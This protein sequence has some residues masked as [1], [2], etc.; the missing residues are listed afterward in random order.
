[1]KKYQGHGGHD[2]DI[3]KLSAAALVKKL[4]VDVTD[5]KKI[6]DK[7]PDIK[8]QL[9]DL[10]TTL[11]MLQNVKPIFHCGAKT[12]ALGPHFGLDPQCE[13]C[14]G[15]ANMLVSKNAKMCVTPNA[16]LQCESMEY[17]L[18]WVPIKRQILA[19][20]MYI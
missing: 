12:L 17:R 14:V 2:E 15:N 19:L 1:M 7:T 20:A 6:T 18:H 13:I 5:L 3:K 11:G 10:K 8:K 9:N 4:T 16:K